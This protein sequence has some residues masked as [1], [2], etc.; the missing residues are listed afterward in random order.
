MLSKVPISVAAMTNE[1][2]DAES[3]RN[4]EDIAR[5]TPGVNLGRGF[6][7]ATNIS[8]R[9]IQGS[10]AG[11]T[12]IYIDET[13]IQVRTLNVA[14]YNIYPQV[15]DLDRVEVLR[16]PQGTLFGSGSQGGTVR[17]ITPSPSFSGDAMYGR[18]EVNAIENGSMGYQA[19]LAYGTALVEGKVGLRVSAYMA[20]TGGYMDRV[21]PV[22]KDAD[23]NFEVKDTNVNQSDT[24]VFR[25]ALGFKPSDRL[26]ITP[27][28]YY[29]KQTMGDNGWYW[30][31]YSDPDNNEYANA[32][33][34]EATASDRFLLGALKVEY[35]GEGF[36]VTS[37]TS[38]FT[39]HENSVYDY[40]VLVPAYYIRKPFAPEF[41]NYPA[42]AEFWQKQN[43][44]TQE[45]RMQSDNSDSP[46]TWLIGGFYQNAHQEV[47][48]D[49]YDRN[50]PLL[51]DTYYDQTVEEYS[52][53]SMLTQNRILF[54]DDYAIDKQYAIFGE[55]GYTLFDQLTFTGGFRYGKM[56]T[57]LRSYATGPFNAGTT[58]IDGTVEETPFTPKFNVAWQVSD[59]TLLYGT[60]AKGFRPGGV[61]R[62][63]PYDPGSTVQSV[64]TC[65]DDQDRNGGPV[66]RL[67]KSDSLWSYEIG[68][69]TSMFDRRLSIDGSAFIIK[70]DDMQV[71]RGACGIAA[72]NNS[73]NSESKGFEL[74]L[75]Y[76]PVNALTLGVGVSYVNA[77]YTKALTT[78]NSSNVVST[79]TAIG[80]AVVTQPWTVTASAQYDT[81]L[82]DRETYVR[83][84]YEYRGGYNR[85]S[86]LNPIT[87]GYNPDTLKPEEYSHVTMR[88]GMKFGNVDISVYAK[89]LTNANPRLYWRYERRG[90]YG[91]NRAGTITPRTFGLTGTFR[92]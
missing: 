75:N 24:Q 5:N 76:R 17:F 89:N 11:T 55:I 21:D 29:Q 61:N 38:K 91:L 30:H 48:E 82:W 77:E 63:I 90:V 18:A 34:T 79:V 73:G 92:Y 8:I 2:M 67:Y 42:Y 62:A 51:I 35:E 45:I 9:G 56:K 86:S 12:G 33:T 22:E 15:F 78:I 69:K 20:H 1:A 54:E 46:F 23:G 3:I 16:G 47:L 87:T 64:I 83:A 19:G 10:G 27:S 7:N 88:A 14:S 66:P 26:T 40:S 57:N 65:T 31:Q 28:I 74:A 50:F 81:S 84:D 52:G 68:A 4:I 41:P 70:W 71:S 25:A 80:D 72:L 59:A 44:T 49:I 43:V 39:R 6:G 13:P 85:P 58:E 32:N 36:T 37:N 60:V 53:L